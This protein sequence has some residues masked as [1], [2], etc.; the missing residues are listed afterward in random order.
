MVVGMEFVRRLAGQKATMT[1]LHDVHHQCTNYNFGMTGL[2]DKLL[3]TLA[4]GYPFARAAPKGEDA[5]SVAGSLDPKGNGIIA[6]MSST[7]Y[8]FA[9]MNLRCFLPRAKSQ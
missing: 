6:A 8:H 3:G 2:T 1:Y 4:E 5:K 9:M 7:S